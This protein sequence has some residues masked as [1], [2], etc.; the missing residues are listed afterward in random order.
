MNPELVSYAKEYIRINIKQLKDEHI[1]IFKKMYSSHNLAANIDD[2]IDNMAIDKLNWAI[3]Q[4][5][6]S[7][8]KEG[9]E[10]WSYRKTFT[11]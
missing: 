6:N 2:V 1:L 3:H 4:I 9:I 10:I 7:L 5:T 11:D 8:L